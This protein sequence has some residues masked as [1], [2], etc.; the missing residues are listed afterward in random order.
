VTRTTVQ[1]A[2]GFTLIEVMIAMGLVALMVTGSVLG[3]RSVAKSDLRSSATRMAGAIRYLFDRAS[4]T[5]KV[6]RMVF[7]FD[8]GKYWAE[9]SD[10][11]FILAGGKE[12]EETRRKLAEKIAKED[13]AKQKQAEK[14]SFFGSAIP[15]KYLPKPFIPKR[16]KFDAFKEM[17]VRPI[18][19]K[20]S[21]VLADIY[22]PRLLKPLDQGKG[23]LYFFPLGMTEAAVIHLTDK[24]GESV[25]SL[26][27]HPLTGRVTVK[28]TLVEADVRDQFDDAGKVVVQ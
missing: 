15:S 8:N 22:T 10:D 9:S 7:D 4:T 1:D 16:A 12:T 11:P 6:H 13:E 20:S 26:I 5:G 3:L 21:V 2:R 14:D 19:L 28:G 18:T 17:T 27:V 24:K 23:Y 25:Y